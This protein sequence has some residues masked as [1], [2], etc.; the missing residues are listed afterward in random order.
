MAEYIDNSVDL[1]Y[2][3]DKIH[4][5]DHHSIDK[6]CCIEIGENGFIFNNGR[7]SAE[8]SAYDAEEYGRK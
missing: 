1:V 5:N 4:F 7:G 3:N 6:S 2:I 8:I